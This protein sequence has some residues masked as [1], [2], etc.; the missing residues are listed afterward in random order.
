MDNF[1]NSTKGT[2][3]EKLAKQKREFTLRMSNI[4][5]PCVRQL[6]LEKNFPQSVIQPSPSNKLKFS[7]GDLTEEYLIFLAEL[8][9]YRVETRQK[10]AE[11]FGIKGH[12]DVVINGW[13]V[14][15]KSASSFSFQKFKDH[16]TPEQDAFGYITQLMSY[17]EDAQDDPV[18]IE[19]NKAAF[20]VF[21]KQHGHICLDIHE[22][23]PNFNWE[24][25]YEARKTI[26]N[27]PDIPDRAFQAK[28]DGY[29][30]PKTKEF[31][32]NGNEYLDVNCS[33]CPVKHKCWD[34][35]RTFIYYGGKPKYFTKI[36]EGK[37]PKVLEITEKE[38]PNTEEEEIT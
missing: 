19:K 8:A 9:G 36:V 35:I 18:V 10:E 3:Q 31:V 24:E 28:P 7:F 37:E 30:N 38:S 13:M 4:G 6:W 25:F 1:L 33:Y 29:K 12:R 22:R 15:V 21:D 2:L 20:L 16:L 17:L 32:P 23:D 34:N 26:V 27:G 14:D 5:R 11:L